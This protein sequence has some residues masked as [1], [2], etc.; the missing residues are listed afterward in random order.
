MEDDI[1]SLEMHVNIQPPDRT[2]EILR[3]F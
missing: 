1:M 2:I 3:F